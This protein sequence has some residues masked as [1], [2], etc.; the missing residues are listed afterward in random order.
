MTLAPISLPSL[1][2]T[3]KVFPVRVLG[4]VSLMVLVTGMLAGLAAVM[5]R[6]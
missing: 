6:F 2:M 4:I 3:G 1:V 5:L